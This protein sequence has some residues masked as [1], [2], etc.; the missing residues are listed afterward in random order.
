MTRK[1]APGQSHASFHGDLPKPGRGS[2][3][4][5]SPHFIGAEMQNT[6]D[7]TCGKCSK[8]EVTYESGGLR[9]G[10]CSVV[11]CK[12]VAHDMAKNFCEHFEG[13]K[14]E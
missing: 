12:V 7:R 3:G 13:V 5:P 1:T 8:F 11:P 2:A 14:D 6:E 4:F 10:L 9:W